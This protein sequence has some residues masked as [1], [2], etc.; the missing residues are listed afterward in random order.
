[1]AVKKKATR[2][3]SGKAVNKPLKKKVASGAKQSAAKKP[4]VK[5]PAVKKKVA[6]AKKS[7]PKKKPVKNTAAA[8]A[9]T[10]KSVTGKPVAKKASTAATRSRPA[11][12]PA[13][14]PKR[15]SASALEKNARIRVTKGRYAGNSGKIVRHDPYL[16]TYFL[17]FDAYKNEPAYKNLEWGPYFPAEFEAMTVK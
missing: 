7:S 15:K 16:G 2:K 3:K 4:A 13:A 5:K 14:Q 12:P 17:T 8:A 1:M 6:A 11:K 10:K 9:K